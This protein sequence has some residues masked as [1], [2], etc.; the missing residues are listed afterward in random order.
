MKRIDFDFKSHV[1]INLV[2]SAKTLSVYD[3][4]EVELTRNGRIIRR[5]I[6]WRCVVNRGRRR[7]ITH[8]R[9]RVI[10][11]RSVIAAAVVII[12]VFIVLSV[13]VFIMAAPVSGKACVGYPD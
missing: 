9:S 4:A 2:K 11:V 8:V 7:V 10:G 12:P 13:M 6:R 3:D 1:V 5:V